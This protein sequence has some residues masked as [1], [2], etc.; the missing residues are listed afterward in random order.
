M[1]LASRL[2]LHCLSD[3]FPTLGRHFEADVPQ[4]MTSLSGPVP[5][6]QVAIDVAEIKRVMV[7]IPEIKEFSLRLTCNGFPEAIVYLDE[8]EGSDLTCVQNKLS[9]R[10][11]GYSIPELHCLSGPLSERRDLDFDLLKQEI[12]RQQS[13]ALSAQRK[14]IAEIVSN[15]LHIDIATIAGD[16]DFFLLGGNSL[17]LGQLAYNIRKRTGI[18][19]GIPTLFRNSTIGGIASIVDEAT[20]HK[21]RSELGGRSPS[22]SS[23]ATLQGICDIH[24]NGARSQLNPLCLIVQA[25]PF[26]FFYPLRAALGC[27]YSITNR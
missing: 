15:L 6:R 26:I 9:E 17:L 4:V 7:S 20:V 2:G 3:K 21:A 27:A 5:C 25:I 19:I 11:P 13:S 23:E 1:G 12:A 10:L 8:A 14:C 16:S 22:M 18:N 24:S